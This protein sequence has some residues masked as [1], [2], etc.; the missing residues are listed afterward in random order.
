MATAQEMVREFDALKANRSTWQ[1]HW[2]EISDYLL[3]EYSTMFG[4]WGS[5]HRTEGDK[6][7]SL[8]YESAPL[9]SLDRAVS[10]TDHLMTPA[11]QVWHYFSSPDPAINED[12][13]ARLYFDAVNEIVRAARD[14]PQANFAS[15]KELIYESLIAYGTGGALYIDDFEGSG[16]RYRHC[17][18]S[19]IYILQNHQ[20]MVD[21]VYRHFS[22]TAHQ[23][24]TKKAWAG[25]LPQKVKDAL[26]NR[27]EEKFEILHCVKPRQARGLYR[28]DGKGMKYASYYIFYSGKDS[29][30]L[31]EGGYNVMPYVIPRYCRAGH[32]VYGRGIGMRILPDVK[33]MNQMALAY[34]KQS[35]LAI[36]PPWAVYDDDEV[37]VPSIIPGSAVAGGLDKEGRFLAQPYQFGQIQFGRENMIDKR[38]D[39]DQHFDLDV[40]EIYLNKDRMT[41][42]EVLQRKAEKIALLYPRLVKLYAEFHAPLIERELDV[43]A[44]NGE[45]PPLPRILQPRRG[46]PKKKYKLKFDSPLTQAQESGRIAS[47]FRLWEQTVAM[48]STTGDPRDREALDRLNLPKAV[49]WAARGSGVPEEL[50]RSD[51]EIAAIA[52][53]RDEAA[54]TET[55]IQAAPA[56]ASVISAL[57][58]MQQAG[59]KA[60]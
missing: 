13:E 56:G 43:L 17:H 23:M 57:A 15:Q 35:H 22:Y 8:I 24:S 10:A 54:Q 32:E 55:A 3:P 27:P 60:A 34:L 19:E 29:V 53:G 49:Q 7:M 16:L 30:I 14:N 51:E 45:L 40:F 36:D 5:P 4:S 38:R 44:R 25:T 39:I 31:S 20:Y 2:T 52:E 21:T 18:L 42:T 6:R 58:K 11:D 41:A 26:K 47:F 33:N 48:V 9:K 59:G 50:L 46:E 37:D 1:S 28:A 12:R